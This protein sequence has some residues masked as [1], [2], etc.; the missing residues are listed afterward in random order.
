MVHKAG[1]YTSKDE[2][3]IEKTFRK[4][5]KRQTLKKYGGRTGKIYKINEV[6]NMQ[7]RVKSYPRL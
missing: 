3:S 5:K 2:M 4:R 6:L 1:G 7:A